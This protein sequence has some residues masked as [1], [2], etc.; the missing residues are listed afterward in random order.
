MK[1]YTSAAPNAPKAIGPYS[2]AV[3]CGSM[4]F[5][6]GQIPLDPVSGT[7]VAGGIKEQT[8]QVLSN[9]NAVLTFLGLTYADVCKTT[10]FLT[11]LSH[12]Q[13]VNELYES[14]LGPTNKPARSTVQVAGLPRGSLV[15][16]E[17]IAMRG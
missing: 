16:I 3:E 11:D 14:A 4:V 8:L 5:L 13:V 7:L 2:Q 6:S 9:I 1:K 10:I 12:F 17:M 15:E